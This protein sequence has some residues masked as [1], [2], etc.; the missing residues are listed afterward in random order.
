MLFIGSVHTP[1]MGQAFV[2]YANGL[3]ADCRLKDSESACEI[4]LINEE[5][6][7]EITQEFNAF[8]ADTNHPKY[9]SA[10]WD[11]P[12]QQIEVGNTSNATKYNSISNI[13]ERAGLLVSIIIIFCTVVF[14]VGMNTQSNLYSYFY[15]APFGQNFD[16][17]Q[18]WRLITPALIH[19]SST[20]LVLN[21]AWWFILGSAIEKRQSSARMLILFMAGTI[22]PNTAQYLITGANFGGLSG[23]VYALFGYCW[24]FSKYKP[25]VG[26][27]IQPALFGFMLI[28]IV[29][30][31]FDILP[32]QMANTSHLLGLI[33]G[34]VLGYIYTRPQKSPNS[35]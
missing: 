30:G 20:H 15:F 2:D 29:I 8:I 31:F 22:I 3:G 6:A 4:W 9:L 16:W 1:R 26:I 28:W 12:N 34:L 32:M 7:L 17:S 5:K 10:S 24:I 11:S 18:P 19:F 33:V 27:N 14:L 21:L 23:M 35:N 25:S 13:I